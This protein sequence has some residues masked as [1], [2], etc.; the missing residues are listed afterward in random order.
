MNWRES[1][2]VTDFTV[3]F[4]LMNTMLTIARTFLNGP[5]DS[6]PWQ[7]PATIGALSGLTTWRT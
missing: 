1:Q 6:L 2:L 3:A 7:I 5:E 4:I